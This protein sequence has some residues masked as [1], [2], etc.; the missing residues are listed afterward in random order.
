MDAVL[1]PSSFLLVYICGVYV[2]ACGYAD[3]ASAVLSCRML[4]CL[5]EIRQLPC[6]KLSS[7][8]LKGKKNSGLGL[9]ENELSA[10]QPSKR[11]RDFTFCRIYL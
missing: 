8:L 2:D 3:V 1:V 10:C 6:M 7:T 5:A 4:L 11:I 9:T